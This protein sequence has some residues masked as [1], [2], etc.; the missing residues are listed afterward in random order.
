[1]NTVSIAWLLDS[2]WD[3]RW[4]RALTAHERRHGERHRGAER[5]RVSDG[6]ASLAAGRAQGT[7][8]GR[9]GRHAL[10]E[11]L[12]HV[13]T[14][15]QLTN[16]QFCDASENIIFLKIREVK[17]FIILKSGSTIK[18]YLIIYFRA[19]SFIMRH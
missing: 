19:Y 5:G 18:K 13:H 10:A 8:L 15:S 17:P 9:R 1:M 14:H 7:A 11:P 12:T 16:D 4:P 3:Q 6:A 2:T